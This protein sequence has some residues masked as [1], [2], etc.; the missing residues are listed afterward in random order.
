MYVTPL[1]QVARLRGAVTGAGGTAR[2]VVASGGGLSSSTLAAITAANTVLNSSSGGGGV[3]AST[4]SG[5]GG[6]A[7]SSANSAGGGVL[8]SVEAVAIA[9]SNA[10]IISQ[11]NEQVRGEITPRLRINASRV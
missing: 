9:A 2:G 5:G 8:V 7:F 11:L 4:A 1:I 3:N 10:R 6:G